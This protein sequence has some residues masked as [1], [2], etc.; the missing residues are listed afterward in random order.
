MWCSGVGLLICGVSVSCTKVRYFVPLS[1]VLR[2]V[3]HQFILDGLVYF[4]LFSLFGF[5][6][7]CFSFMIV[8]NP[9]VFVRVHPW[10]HSH[11]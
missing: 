11:F 7:S 2:D 9:V 10:I 3:C 5:V 6:V 4:R 1:A 8:G